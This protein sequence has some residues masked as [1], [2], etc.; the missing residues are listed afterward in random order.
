M[1]KEKTGKL[2]DHA[3]GCRVR[4][5]MGV[6]IVFSLI[7]TCLAMWHFLLLLEIPTPGVSSYLNISLKEYTEFASFG[8][9]GVLVFAN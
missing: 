2:Y 7:P 4:S 3:K 8:G 6:G 1:T 5:P 9:C